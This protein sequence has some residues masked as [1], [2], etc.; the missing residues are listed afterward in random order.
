M[1]TEQ[2]YRDEQ[3]RWRINFFRVVSIAIVILIGLLIIA[4]R[5]SVDLIEDADIVLVSLIIVLLILNRVVKKGLLL[6]PSIALIV[7]SWSAMTYLMWAG[8]GVYDGAVI[9]YFGVLILCYLLL[10][11]IYTLF[12]LL[13]S[14][15]SIWFCAY[16]QYLGLFIPEPPETV[17]L[18]SR[19]VTVVLLIVFSLGFAY[20]RRINTYIIQITKELSERIKAEKALQESKEDY[21]HLFEQASDGILIGNM[22][23]EILLTN[24]AMTNL[25]GYSEEE[26]LGRD[27]NVLF[28]HEE[29]INKPLRY[30]LLQ[31]GEVVVCTREIFRKDGSKLPVEMRTKA[32]PDGRLQSFFTDIS[33]KLAT[34][35]TLQDFERIFS[36]STNPIWVASFDGTFQRVNPSFVEISGYKMEDF[37]GSTIAQF[38]HPDDVEW[39]INYV[40]QK[41]QEKVSQFSF[42]NRFITKDGKIIW[43]SWLLQPIYDEGT[44]FSV[45]HDITNIK[46]VEE[47][48]IKA[49]EKA[50][51]SDRLKTAFLANMSHEIRTPMNGILG[52]SDMFLDPDITDEEKKHYA[53]IV[54]NSGK[55][56]MTMLDDIIDI[57]RIET[58][59]MEIVIE[60]VKVNAL[61]ND[62]YDFFNSQYHDL[63]LDFTV[64][65]SLSNTKS[66]IST[67]KLRLN[68]ILSNLLANAFKFTT[69][70]FI[71]YGYKKK[72]KMLEF[73]VRDSGIGIPEEAQQLIFNRFQQA[74][75]DITRNYGGTGLGLSISKKLTELLGGKI[76]LAS[77]PGKGST[78]YFTIPYVQEKIVHPSR[79]K[80]PETKTKKTKLKEILVVEDDAINFEFLNKLLIQEGYKVKHVNNGKSAIEAV[81]DSD[82]IDLIL[83]DIKLPKVDGIEATRRIKE[84]KPKIPIIAQT[85]FAM[86]G[87]K[88]QVLKAG[89]DDYLAKPISKEQLFDMIDKYLN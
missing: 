58:G 31:Q 20:L 42:E 44:A 8:D 5:L 67:D 55:R 63:R 9:G 29:L 16:M 71:K 57:S 33:E 74:N 48:L 69:R 27:I 59:K 84:I 61:L 1:L 32:L 7:L 81:K 56:L 22:D 77:E 21:Q 64:E 75:Q 79:L 23:G 45:G 10:D 34:Q 40:A 12:V 80:K 3:K 17:F 50:E 65:K 62:L 52:F 60:P 54:I 18:Y 26:L 47:E 78:F 53:Q 13:A 86:S 30:D 25:S 76:W 41:V 68:Q 72:G 36:L 19:D 6:G 51:E 43:Y 85:A 24:V 88:D 37:I 89:F 28:T 83:M 66:I 39:T 2:L 38:I 73:Y 70:G 14:L 35:K 49:K 87:D 4:R 46:L 15:I 11:W 82:M